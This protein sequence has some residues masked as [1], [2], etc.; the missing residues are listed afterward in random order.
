MCGRRSSTGSLDEGSIGSG[1]GRSGLR[2][3][4]STM[5]KSQFGDKI[6]PFGDHLE[7]L[8]RRLIFALLGILPILVASLVIGKS[9]LNFL[10]R[11]IAAAL[12]RGGLP[13]ALQVTGPF[14][15][16]SAYMQVSIVLTILV[17]APWIVYQFWRFVAPGL[18]SHERRFAYLLAPMSALLTGLS[19]LFLYY[20]MLPTTLAFF[21]AFNSSLPTVQVEAAPV[22][23]GVVLSVATILKHDPV[24]PPVGA[25]WYNATI[26]QLRICV[27][28]K[29]GAKIVNST[30][31]VGAS[32]ISQQYRV[33]DCVGMV[34]TFAL[35]L[36][37]AFQMPVVVLL[38]GW[39][40]LVNPGMLTK[41]R[42]HTLLIC[43]VLGAVLTPADPVS[44]LL[45][46]IPL[47]VLF[48]L[49]VFLLR[50]LP[51]GRVTGEAAGPGEHRTGDEDP[52]AKPDDQ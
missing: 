46:A 39:A 2:G 36:A 21:V 40:G 3:T 49:G 7:E 42:R 4:L 51:A 32:L 47:Y 33:A 29:T 34:L 8:R 12:E 22:P 35:A 52:F 44:M 24:D 27:I 28:D 17:G 20:V 41:Y 18:Y 38:L 6:M 13:P 23:E 9:V 14:E 19:G 43:A 10:L 26:N 15:M 25:M 50:A 16:F 45:L 31:M 48:E 30:S 37:I 5:P 1:S 11:P